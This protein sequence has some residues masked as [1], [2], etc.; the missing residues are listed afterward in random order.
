MGRAEVPDKP[1]QIT[2]QSGEDLDNND[3]EQVGKKCA[4]ERL[5][6]CNLHGSLI[7]NIF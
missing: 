4:G 1:A 2:D 7:C 3:N 6:I 5:N